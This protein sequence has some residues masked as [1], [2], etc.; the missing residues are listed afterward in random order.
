[1]GSTI[2]KVALVSTED[3]TKPRLRQ[4]RRVGQV[5]VD[6]EMLPA[7]Q[8]GKEEKE[9]MSKRGLYPKYRVEKRDGTPTD[10][11]AEY[12]VLRVDA[13]RHARVA[14]AAY[15]ESVRAENPRLSCDLR[16]WLDTLKR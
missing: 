9:F 3:M 10:L 7:P 6:R 5:K 8:G 1:M 15:A 11:E 12:F 2:P 13:D 16:M 14:L 4:N